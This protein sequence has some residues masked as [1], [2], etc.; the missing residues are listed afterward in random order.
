LITARD[1]RERHEANL[2]VQKMEAELRRVLSSVS[3]CLWSAEIDERGRWH[4]RLVSPVIEKITG[5]PAPFFDRPARWHRVIHPDDL[6]RYKAAFAAP[7]PGQPI[8]I[9]FRV[10]R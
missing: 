10:R 4:Y 2:R 7:Q 6:A 3:D 1:V 9:E 5:R 8:E